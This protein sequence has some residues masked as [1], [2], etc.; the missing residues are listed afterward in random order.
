MWACLYEFS[1]RVQNYHV[2]LIFHKI[3][4][5]CIIKLSVCVGACLYEF[6]VRVQN[7]HVQLIFHKIAIDCI[8]NFY[9]TLKSCYTPGHSA[10]QAM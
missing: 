1:V 2:Q 8:I 10:L 6:S 9:N 4:I 7:H 3:A 5:D